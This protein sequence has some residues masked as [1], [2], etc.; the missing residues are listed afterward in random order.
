VLSRPQRLTARLRRRQVRRVEIPAGT[1]ASI[2]GDPGPQIFF[3]QRGTGN[4]TTHSG[5]AWPPVSFQPQ[6]VQH[7]AGSC[8]AGQMHAAHT[9][10]TVDVRQMT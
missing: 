10:W 1:S 2:G 9:C 3:V 4:A 7:G 8:L 6:R 5:F